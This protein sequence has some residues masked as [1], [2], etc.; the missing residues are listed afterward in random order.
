MGLRYIS[1]QTGQTASSYRWWDMVSKA[2]SSGELSQNGPLLASGGD[3][4]PS[5]HDQLFSNQD[6]PKSN[7]K[8]KQY[9]SFYSLYMKVTLSHQRIIAKA[10][11]MR[12]TVQNLSDHKKEK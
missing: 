2:H 8:I 1:W 7:T 3:Q 4:E 10:L 11:S 9:K 6:V 12:K 5:V